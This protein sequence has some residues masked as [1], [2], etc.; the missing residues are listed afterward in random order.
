VARKI[1]M[2]RGI[3][4][5]VAVVALTVWPGQAVNAKTKPL[6]VIEPGKGNPR[7]SEGDLIEL[8]DGR[9]CLIYTRFTGGSGDHA[10]ADL[11]MRISQDKGASWSSDKIVV[12]RTG[13]LNIMSVSLILRRQEKD[14]YSLEQ[15]TFDN[16]VGHT[17]T[18]EM[19]KQTLH[20]LKKHL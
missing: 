1:Q 17:Y 14:G 7:N 3:S 11:A 4:I 13:G 16:G 19:W 10:A 5:L 9:L 6:W 12:R 15:F 2:K 8:K 20:W 18:P